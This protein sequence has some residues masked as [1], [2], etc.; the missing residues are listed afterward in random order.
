MEIINAD[1]WELYKRNDTLIC[2]TTNGTVKNNGE[3]VMGAGCAKQCAE[4]YPWFPAALGAHIKRCGNTLTSFSD[5]V[6]FPVKH[7]WWEDAD[8]DLIKQSYIDLK[9][10]VLDEYVYLPKPGCGNG[11]LSWDQVKEVLEPLASEY[12]IIVD[13]EH[14]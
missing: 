8:L 14:K 1:L 4:L 6:T 7:N 12:I 11:K 2:I 3:A 5:I 9:S 13:W 10:R